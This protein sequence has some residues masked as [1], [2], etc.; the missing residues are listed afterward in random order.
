MVYHIGG[1]DGEF[2]KVEVFQK[3][4]G[5]HVLFV[6]FEIR[7]DDEEALT[8]KKYKSDGP[9]VVSIGRCISYE[10]NETSFYIN[11]YP[12]SSSLFKPTKLIPNEDP[13]Y[14]PGHGATWGL[15]TE[16]EREI[17]VKTWS[18]PQ[19]IEEFDLPPPDFLSIDA[20]GAELDIL[21][22]AE[23]LFEKSILGTI[24]EGEFFELYDGQGLFHEQLEFYLQ[25][26]F[27]LIDPFKML[28]FHSGPRMPGERFLTMA[29]SSFIRFANP[30][31]DQDSVWGNVALQKMDDKK[32]IKLLA[33]A[34]GLGLYSYLATLGA[35]IIDERP[36][37][38]EIL[39]S[40][41]KPLVDTI[42]FSSFVRGHL[43]NYNKDRDFFLN[44]NFDEENLRFS[45][46]TSWDK[47]NR[48]CGRIWRA[49]KRRV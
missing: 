36:A 46:P 28:R 22:G 3:I 40:S 18:L 1:G 5:K 2:G 33:I 26:G 37:A 21:K 9:D 16:L 35:Y 39:K 47:F 25:H 14:G 6:E 31:L 17:K 13:G 41:P 42:E 4:F 15:N 43:S 19:V 11:K 27:R 45:T 23:S 32:L 12:L 49:I 34:R 44:L 38:L 29:E 7:S 24:T 10:E 30:T 20:Q 8:I 48:L